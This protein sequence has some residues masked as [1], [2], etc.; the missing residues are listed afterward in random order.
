MAV[1]SNR[2]ARFWD[3]FLDVGVSLLPLWL[4]GWVFVVLAVQ[5]LLRL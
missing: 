2:V 4:F 1:W 3:V 5:W